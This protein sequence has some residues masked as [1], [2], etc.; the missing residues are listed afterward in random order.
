M[1][2]FENHVE[3]LVSMPE[4]EFLIVMGEGFFCEPCAG[5]I[6]N[7]VYYS[8]REIYQAYWARN[9]DAEPLV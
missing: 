9:H 6:R 4:W 8:E 1:G 3:A 7:G 2:D 5:H